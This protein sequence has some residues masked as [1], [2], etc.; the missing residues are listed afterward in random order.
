MESLTLLGVLELSRLPVNGARSVLSNIFLLGE[1]ADVTLR[2]VFSLG[3]REAE[4]FSGFLHGQREL[5]KR[6]VGLLRIQR[7]G[8]C[9]QI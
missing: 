4:D 3:I 2:L 7:L 6:G 8:K 5:A 9:R 1:P